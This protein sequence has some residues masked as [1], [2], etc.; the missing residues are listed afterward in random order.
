MRA[1]PARTPGCVSRLWH[2]VPVAA[3]LVA[4]SAAGPAAG[5]TTAASQ[6]ESDARRNAVAPTSK[7]LASGRT[8]AARSARKAAFSEQKLVAL[9]PE[10]IGDWKRTGYGNP[11]SE[12]GHDVMPAMQ[13][14][15]ERGTEEADVEMSDLGQAGILAARESASAVPGERA[16]DSGR[17]RTYRAGERVFRE[18]R[19][20][21][22]G[23]TSVSVVLPNGLSIRVSGRRTDGAGLQQ[24]LEGIDLAGAEALR[25]SA[26]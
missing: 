1:M 8:T 10:R 20:A 17:E 11:I 5:A 4:A 21:Q 16:T 9:L 2:A 19:D 13:A 12:T 23:T 14:Q 24:V 26:K 18:S 25:R 6:A 7:A 15:Y 22:T 3:A